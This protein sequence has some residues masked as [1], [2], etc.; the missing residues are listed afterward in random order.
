MNK[1]LPKPNRDEESE[2]IDNK[3]NYDYK[4]KLNGNLVYQIS[5]ISHLLKI[6]ITKTWEL[7]HTGE[8]PSINIGRR[9]LVS[10]DDLIEFIN[11]KRTST[12]LEVK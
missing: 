2:L 3:G 11:Q 5:E 12:T 7:I 9:R 10:H 4:S 1:E 6:G 8:L